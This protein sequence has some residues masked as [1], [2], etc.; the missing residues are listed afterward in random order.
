MKAVFGSYIIISV[1]T[2]PNGQSLVVNG[3]GLTVIVCGDEM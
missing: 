2:L 3:K 1:P